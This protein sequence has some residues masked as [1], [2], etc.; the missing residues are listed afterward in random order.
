MPPK[1]PLINVMERAARKAGRALVRDFGEVENL[2]VSQKGPGDF[3]SAADTR[4]EKT[5]HAE[6]SR[7]RP[8]FGFLLEEGGEIAGRDETHRWVIDP[9]DGT[10]N[11]LHGLP[12]FCISIA[13]EQRMRRAG[14]W[15]SEI[16]AGLVYDP[17]RDDSYWAEKGQGAYLNDRRLRVSG[18]KDLGSAV[19]ASGFPVLGRAD[20]KRFLAQYEAMMDHVAGLRRFGAAALD[21]AFVAAGRFEGFWEQGLNAWD[22]AA[23]LLL[24]REAGGFV[25]DLDGRDTMMESGSIIASNAHLHGDLQRILNTP[26]PA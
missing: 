20:H 2:Q 13:V 4:S 1:S 24:V 8:D 15:Q 17:L 25:T 23:G 12:Q 22:I 19:I 18:R 9:L 3:V 6:L 11:F 5:L 16:L 14:R 10:T 21:L 26:R 7:A